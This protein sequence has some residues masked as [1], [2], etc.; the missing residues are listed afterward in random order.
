MDTPETPNNQRFADYLK[1]WRE[2]FQLSQEQLAER[3]GSS[4]RHISRLENGISMPSE[5]LTTQIAE[6]LK[7]GRRDSSHLRIA[8]GYATKETPQDFHGPELKWLRSAMLRT[9]QALDPYPTTLTDSSGRILMVNK[10]WAGFYQDKVDAERLRQTAN[11]YDFLFNDGGSSALTEEWK[12]ALSLIIMAFKQN[13]ML[14]G[15][16]QETQT[17]QR[18][19]NYPSVPADWMQRAARLE[20]RASFKIRIEHQGKLQAFYSVSQTV[21]A[22]GPAAYLTEPKLSVN[23][24]YPEDAGLNLTDLPNSAVEHPLLFY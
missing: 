16:A 4:A 9:L 20:P 12:N 17:L 11:L 15:S 22:I 3:V 23:T 7:L 6:A 24:L 10:A 18:I 21:G 2:V 19:L 1:F 5:A 13:V 8:A 14:D